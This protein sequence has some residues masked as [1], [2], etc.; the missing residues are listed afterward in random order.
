MAELLTNGGSRVMKKVMVPAFLVLLSVAAGPALAEETAAPADRA[1]HLAFGLGFGPMAGTQDGTVLGLAFH[2]DYFVSDEV[3]IGPLLQ[4]GFENDFTLVGLSG[5]LKYTF[6]VPNQPALH[7]HV[8]A[9]LGFVHV[10]NNNDDTDFLVPIGGGI[11]VEVARNL[12]LNSTLLINVTGLDDDIFLNWLFG[13][14]V[15]I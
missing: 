9:G 13:F 4:L 8:Q 3:A 11:D 5:Q 10:D 1:G 12:F 2:G 7:P 6:N 15:M 14:K